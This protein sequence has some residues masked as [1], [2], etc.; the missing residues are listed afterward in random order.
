MVLNHPNVSNRHCLI[1]QVARDAQVCVFLRDLSSRGTFVNQTLVGCNRVVELKDGDEINI[2]DSAQFVFR[3]SG[4]IRRSFALHYTRLECLGNGHLGKVFLCIEKSTGKRFA[5]KIY[6]LSATR[7]EQ[8]LKESI[9]AELNLMGL[10]HRNIIFM[11]EAFEDKLSSSHVIQ[12]AEKGDLF[13]F[14]VRKSKLSEDETRHIFKQLFDAVKYLVSVIYSFV[15]ILLTSRSISQHDRNIVHRDLKPENILL[16]DEEPSVALCS[17]DLSITIPHESF[18]TTLCGTPSY[19]AP[20]VLAESRHRRY[21][22]EVDIWSL[23]VVLYICLC[24][25]PPFSDQ[26]YSKDFPYTL[27]Q[28]IKSARFD[29]PSPYWDSVSDSAR[30]GQRSLRYSIFA[31]VLTCSKWI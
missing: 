4:L 9:T 27:S 26:L 7:S 22:R 2:F 21:G 1:Y 10:C 3:P 12:I 19:I 11:K 6:E 14:I 31:C 8:G 15:A 5:V 28:Q 18:D 17:F 29:Y 24:G 16:L 25:S 23:G 13:G 30:K 20:E